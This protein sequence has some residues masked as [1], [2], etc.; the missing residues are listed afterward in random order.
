MYKIW[1]RGPRGRRSRAHAMATAAWK[2]CWP[3]CASIRFFES[4]G[5]RIGTKERAVLGVFR[6]ELRK[7]AKRALMACRMGGIE[8]RF[9]ALYRGSG[10]AMPNGAD[11]SRGFHANQ[12]TKVRSVAGR[13][14]ACRSPFA[15]NVNYWRQNVRNV[16]LALVFARTEYGCDGVSGRDLH[17]HHRRSCLGFLL[18]GVRDRQNAARREG[19]LHRRR[20]IAFARRNLS[21]HHGAGMEGIRRDR[22]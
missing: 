20:A 6:F 2:V 17:Q 18:L 15:M 21:G 22:Q 8:W 5:S 10:G 14:A 3:A 16:D 11:V 1:R 4:L 19:R 12:E 13:S 7:G 9:F